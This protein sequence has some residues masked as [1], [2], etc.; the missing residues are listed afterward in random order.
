MATLP[1]T[2]HSPAQPHAVLC[3]P[4]EGVGSD[5][6]G[7]Q[8]GETPNSRHQLWGGVVETEAYSRGNP[9]TRGYRRLSPSNET[10]VGEP[11]HFYVY[12]SY[13]IHHCV[14]VVTNRQ[15]DAQ[16]QRQ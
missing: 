8:V 3:C 4:A 9:A 7:L 13:G 2:K 5:L 16:A 11:G 10:L 1:V 14:N 12:V 6:M 15:A